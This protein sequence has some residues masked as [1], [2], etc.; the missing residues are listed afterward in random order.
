MITAT[1]PRTGRWE[2]TPARTSVGFAVR[3][4]GVAT[5]RGQ[6]PVTAAW[7]DV[8]AAG[9]LAA[10]RAK[11]D[12]T[13]IDTGNP[14]RDRDLRKTRL[15]D[16]TRHS[17]LTFEGIV[18]GMIVE[19]VL[20]GLAATRVSLDVVSVT[21]GE[22]GTVA[23]HATATLDRAALGVRAP[24]FL[25]GRRIVAVIDVTFAPPSAHPRRAAGGG[26]DEGRSP[27]VNLNAEGK[28]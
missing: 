20:T 4:F 5:V 19:G 10:V 26:D 27:V 14:R 9:R 18:D 11:L 2:L 16:T 1:A 8:D 21:P 17:T 7:V 3:N 25:I 24:R 23:A 28:Q 12:L 15:L 22:S 13:G 6:I